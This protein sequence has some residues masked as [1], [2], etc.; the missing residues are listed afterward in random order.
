MQWI[1]ALRKQ[2][3]FFVVAYDRDGNE[4]HREQVKFANVAT[5]G[6][7]TPA[8]LHVTN[9]NNITGTY[10]GDVSKITVTVND[11]LYKGG[12]VA[13]GTFKFYSKDKIKAN[14]D[15][16]VIHAYDAAGELLDTQTLQFIDTVTTTGA[17]QPN[18]MVVHD[19][20]Y[21]T[22]TYQGDVKSVRVTVDGQPYKGGT[23]IDGDFKFYAFDKIQSPDSH[24]IIEALDANGKI[25]DTKTVQLQPRA[26]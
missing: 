8:M 25:L 5:E 20:K 14:T 15:T 10:A 13:N 26:K 3:A 12:T 1:K 19:A 16:V 9:D 24:V 6:K 23:L 7:L 21:I 18:M 2:I 4:L 17:I 22:G 11:V